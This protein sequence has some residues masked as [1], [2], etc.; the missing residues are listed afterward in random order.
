MTDLNLE[1]L[2]YTLVAIF[3]GMAFVK[4]VQLGYTW[5]PVMGMFLYGFVAQKWTKRLI[6]KYR[7]Q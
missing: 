3:A 7:R 2:V 4:F 5:Q 1:E 6:S